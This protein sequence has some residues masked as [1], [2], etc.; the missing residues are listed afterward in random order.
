MIPKPLPP[1]VRPLHPIGRHNVLLT[2]T[3]APCRRASA[4]GWLPG[5]IVAALILGFL[6]FPMVGAK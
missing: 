6:V 4:W 2:M 1:H 5:V 3:G